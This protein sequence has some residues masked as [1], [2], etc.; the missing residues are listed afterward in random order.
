LNNRLIAGG[1]VLAKLGAA[2]NSPPLF[3]SLAEAHDGY[4]IDRS[5]GDEFSSG[6]A[7]TTKFVLFPPKSA[8]AAEIGKFGT[9][10]WLF[11]ERARR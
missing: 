6:V 8:D 1:A 10:E 2:V 11:K 7:R 9:V 4:V 3:T 5:T